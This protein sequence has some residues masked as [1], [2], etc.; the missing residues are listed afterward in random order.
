MDKCAKKQV[1]KY[2][3]LNVKR[4]RDVLS[5]LHASQETEFTV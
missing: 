4:E 2:T 1:I 3:D 5:L